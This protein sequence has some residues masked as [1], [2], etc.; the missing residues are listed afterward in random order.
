MKV[1]QIATTDDIEAYIEGCL[2]D[3]ELGISEKEETL[4]HIAELVAYVYNKAK[5][6][7]TTQNK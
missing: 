2:N 3:F 6:E 4:V 5:N 7:E 1:E